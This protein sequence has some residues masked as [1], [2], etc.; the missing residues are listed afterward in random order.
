ME[1]VIGGGGLLLGRWQVRESSPRNTTETFAASQTTTAP[2]V[3]GARGADAA[4]RAR[5]ADVRR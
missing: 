2:I 4:R 1:L 5:G 3:I